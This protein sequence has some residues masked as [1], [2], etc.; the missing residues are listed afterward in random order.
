MEQLSPSGAADDETQTL[1]R[2]AARL[3]QAA[4]DAGRADVVA[5]VD[6]VIGLLAGDS[7]SGDGGPHKSA[8]SVIKFLD[9]LG[10]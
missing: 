8:S 5:K 4:A 1:V 2:M 9:G 10:F 7:P 3:R 6:E